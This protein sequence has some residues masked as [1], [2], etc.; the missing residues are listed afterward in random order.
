MYQ[1]TKCIISSVKSGKEGNLS[2]QFYLKSDGIVIIFDLTEELIEWNLKYQ[3]K[4]IQKDNKYRIGTP[5]LLLGMYKGIQTEKPRTI[6]FDELSTFAKT[7]NMQ[8]FEN[9]V[10]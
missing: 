1:N 3:L 4:E 5:I 7:Q 10:K 6:E 8:Y 9:D 2:D